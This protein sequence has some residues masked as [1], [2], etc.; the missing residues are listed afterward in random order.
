[1]IPVITPE[2]KKLVPF[3]IE[4]ASDLWIVQEF[5]RQQSEPETQKEPRH[6][7]AKTR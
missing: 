2:Q 1:M 4:T 6:G 5:I 3:P 7:K